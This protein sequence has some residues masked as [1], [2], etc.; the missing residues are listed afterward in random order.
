MRAWLKVNSSCTGAS[1]NTSPGAGDA[2]L[3]VGT[4]AANAESMAPGS[5]SVTAISAVKI[6]AVNRARTAPARRAGT[7]GR[8]R[9]GPARM[10]ATGGV[11]PARA[12]RWRSSVR[13]RALKD[14]R[15]VPRPSPSG[16]TN[17]ATMRCVAASRRDRVVSR[18]C[19]EGSGGRRRRGMN[20]LTPWNSSAG[21]FSLPRPGNFPLLPVRCCRFVARVRGAG[22]CRAG[23]GCRFAAAGSCRAG[24]GCG[25]VPG[26]RFVPGRGQ[27]EAAPRW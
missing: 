9:Q 10:S 5:I 21:V 27:V 20:A 11:R 8:D 4:V 23:P 25:F 3:R 16:Q 17:G 2:D 13:A 6:S 22:S 24:P 19:S 14:R 26:C 1:T 7:A 15:D 12:W 18:S